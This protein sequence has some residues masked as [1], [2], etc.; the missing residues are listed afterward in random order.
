MTHSYPRTFASG[1]RSM[2]QLSQHRGFTLIEVMIVVAIVA[3]LAAIAL[4]AYSD[5][6]RRGQVPEAFTYLSDFKVKMEQYFQDNRNYGTT[7]CADGTNAPS[8]SNFATPQAKYFTFTCTLNDGNYVL[9][10][11]GSAG[12]AT[13]HIYTIS[14]TGAKTTTRLKGHTVTMNCWAVKEGDC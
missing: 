8:W 11:T 4:P 14:N 5:H 7:A 6:M 12:R 10:A 3:I 1:R 13:G 2:R 9:T